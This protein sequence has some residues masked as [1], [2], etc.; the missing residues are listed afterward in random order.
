MLEELIARV[1]AF[2]VLSYVITIG[3]TYLNA[4]IVALYRNVFDFDLVP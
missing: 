2:E 4:T 1:P 3:K